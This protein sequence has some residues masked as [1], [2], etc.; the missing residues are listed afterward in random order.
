MRGLALAALAMVA[1]PMVPK[2]PPSPT[3][4]PVPCKERKP[5]Q[6]DEP[7]AAQRALPGLF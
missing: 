4:K 2:P 6:P 5:L 3:A 7:S 1:G